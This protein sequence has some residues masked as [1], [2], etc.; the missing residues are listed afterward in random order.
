MSLNENNQPKNCNYG[1]CFFKILY[2]NEYNI[3]VKIAQKLRTI[4][5]CKNIN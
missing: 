5:K 3:Y 4:K 2:L 1:K